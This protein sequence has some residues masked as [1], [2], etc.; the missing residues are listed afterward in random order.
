MKQFFHRSAIKSA[1]MIMVSLLLS[2]VVLAQKKITG[3]VVDAKTGATIA[4]ASVVAKGSK[5]V[6]Q[7]LLMVHLLSPYQKLLTH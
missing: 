5:V 4:S 3:S 1:S 6:Q 2:V 7:L